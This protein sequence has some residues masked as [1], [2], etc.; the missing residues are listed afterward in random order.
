MSSVEYVDPTILPTGSVPVHPTVHT[1]PRFPHIQIDPVMSVRTPLV[2]TR[3][4]FV[5]IGVPPPQPQ[6]PP[7]PHPQLGGVALRVIVS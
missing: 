6:P 3:L 2:H 4:A 1:C 5:H 7:Q